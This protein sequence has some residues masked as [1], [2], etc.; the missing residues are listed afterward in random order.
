[1]SGQRNYKTIDRK[2]FSFLSKV[3]E[4]R[5]MRHTNEAFLEITSKILFAQITIK[6]LSV[7]ALYILYFI[8]SSFY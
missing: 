8:S 7:C 6:V 2:D 3:S 4:T 1:M 5:T